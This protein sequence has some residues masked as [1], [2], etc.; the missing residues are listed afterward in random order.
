MLPRMEFPRKLSSVRKVKFPSDEGISP[1]I[2]FSNK[3]RTCSFGRH[4]TEIDMLPVRI[5]FS[6]AICQIFQVPNF[7]WDGTRYRIRYK[8]S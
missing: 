6:M 3:D 4:P 1:E 5:H 7:C 2:L 8:I